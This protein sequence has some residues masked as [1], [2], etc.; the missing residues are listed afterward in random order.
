MADT[1]I[2]FYPPSGGEPV[3]ALPEYK[4]YYLGKGWKEESIKQEKPKA[5]GK[6]D[7]KTK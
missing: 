4:D 3:K 6:T 7:R 5:D 2:T 1:R